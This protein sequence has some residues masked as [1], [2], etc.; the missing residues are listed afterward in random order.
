M[1]ARS[2]HFPFP[3]RTCI[4]NTPDSTVSPRFF[5]TMHITHHTNTTGTTKQHFPQPQ[6]TPP[7]TPEKFPK[8]PRRNRRHSFPSPP[9]QCRLRSRVRLPTS[10]S[11]A[12][13]W[14]PWSRRPSSPSSAS[15]STRYGYPLFLPPPSS[16]LHS[17][18]L[19][20]LLLLLPC[21]ALHRQLPLLP[22][23]PLALALALARVAKRPAA[24]EAREEEA[25]ANLFSPPRPLFFPQRL[26]PS[27]SFLLLLLLLLLPAFLRFPTSTRCAS[28]AAA[29]GR[30]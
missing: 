25:R 29:S 12:K 24:G 14:P 19:L 7:G 5:C 1:R 17:L 30:P 3:H 26:P 15:A 16:A 8:K 2:V 4:A 21:C 10:R 28:S 9:P 6:R 13:A 27:H 22:S 20:L 18:L 11:A 23:P